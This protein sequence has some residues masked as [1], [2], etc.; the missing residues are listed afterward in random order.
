MNVT[1]RRIGPQAK[2][3]FACSDRI[4]P[5]ARSF[6]AYVDGRWRR[7]EVTWIR[8]DTSLRWMLNALD[9][10]RFLDSVICLG[11][12]PDFHLGLADEADLICRD[13]T[14]ALRSTLALRRVD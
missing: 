8:A 6:S 13:A 4:V 5:G 7:C 12:A 9:D 1:P 14:V 11:S 2:A 10:Q 3:G